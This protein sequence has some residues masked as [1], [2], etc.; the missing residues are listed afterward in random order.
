MQVNGYP[1][2]LEGY[3]VALATCYRAYKRDFSL[4]DLQFPWEKVVE[5]PPAA[6]SPITEAAA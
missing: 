2:A 4:P 1:R 3:L 6:S 5:Q